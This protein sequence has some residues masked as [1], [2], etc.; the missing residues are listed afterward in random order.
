MF[1]R[2]DSERNAKIM[3]KAVNERKLD[4]NRYKVGLFIYFL[5]SVKM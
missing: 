1:T 2:L 4:A 3:K 5:H